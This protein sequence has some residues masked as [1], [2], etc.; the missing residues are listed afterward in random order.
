MQ[1]KRLTIRKFQRR[2][3]EDLYHLLSDRDVMRYLQAPFTREET[4]AFLQKAGLSVS[5]LIYAVE[6]RGGSFVGYVIYHPYDKNSFE[7]GWVLCKHAWGRGY[8]QEL[9]AALIQNAKTQYLVLECAPEQIATKRIALKNQFLYVGN[10]DGCDVYRLEIR[11]EGFPGEKG[12]QQWNLSKSENTRSW[13][14]KRRCGSTKNGAFPWKLMK[15][16]WGRA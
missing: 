1:T 10:V 11:T 3:L 12:S 14:P 2:D 4:E 8:A 13:P 9:T 6:D 5:P 16:A 7:I 15:K